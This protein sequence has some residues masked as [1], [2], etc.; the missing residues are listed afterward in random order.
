MLPTVYKEN[1]IGEFRNKCRTTLMGSEEQ[2][3]GWRD[4]SK[5][6]RPPRGM[7]RD[8][9]RMHGKRREKVC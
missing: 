2:G 1:G 5:D 7:L 6:R 4:V 9:I 8:S 3:G